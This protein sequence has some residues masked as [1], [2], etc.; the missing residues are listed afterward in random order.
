MEAQAAAPSTAWQAD[1][2]ARALHAAAQPLVLL[3]TRLR[4]RVPADPAATRRALVEAVDRFERELAAADWEPRG[5]AAASY[6]LCTWLDEVVAGTPW[7]GP[8]GAAL[9]ERFHGET[10]GGERVLRLLARLAERPQ[11][12]AALLELFHAC[13][14]LGLAGA[15]R[16][17]AAAASALD[18]LRARVFGVLPAR[19]P[20]LSP[21]W[22]SAV[23]AAP[24]GGGR[25]RFV[26]GAL[27]ALALGALAV[28]SAAQV[29]L[30]RRV[31]QVFV[32]MHRLSAGAGP[33]APAQAAAA[34]RLA[35]AFAA[36]IAAGRL[37]V[38]D[39]AHRSLVSLPAETLFDNG[40][41][42][43]AAP[44]AALLARL[45][46]VLAGRS[47]KLV[48][49]GHT[50]GQ[51]LRTAR[52][53]SAWHQSHEWARV[54]ADQLARGVPAE[55]LAVEGAGDLADPAEAALPRRRVDVVYFP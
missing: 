31:D 29:L 51:D 8:G 7:G 37:R 16:G 2:R 21:P 47:G 22:R 48:V 33:A 14:S 43:L 5:V 27:I 41:A 38:R 53:P 45:A 19:A 23:A 28:Y 24:A 50:D 52:L 4:H 9:L 12:N 30:A 55:R 1:P 25:R 10:E 17:Q 15:W 11:E 42:Q 40:D 44:A 54:V 26:V 49:V 3:A 46:G 36:D 39:E 18:P 20:A 13:L 34:D 35:G 6:L 32:A